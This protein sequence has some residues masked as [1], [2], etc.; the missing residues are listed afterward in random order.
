LKYTV[1]LCWGKKD[2][3]EESC[4]CDNH[5]PNIPRLGKNSLGPVSAEGVKDSDRCHKL[6]R[7]TSSRLVLSTGVNKDSGDKNKQNLDCRNPDDAIRPSRLLAMVLA[8]AVL[9]AGP[10]R[11]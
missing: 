5:F 3:P 2:D 7:I 8:I 6:Q 10:Q 9:M 1:D 4:K 11:S